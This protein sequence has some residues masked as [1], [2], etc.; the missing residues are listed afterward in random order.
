M[1]T[2]TSLSS[3]AWGS[4]DDADDDEY[5]YDV[6]GEYEKCGPTLTSRAPSPISPSD[7]TDELVNYLFL[8]KD[9]RLLV[10]DAAHTAHTAHAAAPSTPEKM[11]MRTTSAASASPCRMAT[12]GGLANG[13]LDSSLPR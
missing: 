3:A 10:A 5:E 7:I 11:Q 6:F 12:R 4:L 8:V 1:K 13:R 2:P 9:I